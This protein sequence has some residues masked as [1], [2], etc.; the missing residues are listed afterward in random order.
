M[1]NLYIFNYTIVKRL[2]K[3]LIEREMKMKR[4]FILLNIFVFVCLTVALGVRQAAAVPITTLFNTGVNNDGT[5]R[6][7]GETELHYTI[8]S[9]PI[10]GNLL[11]RTSAGGFPISTGAWTDDNTISTWITP[12]F[13]ED[14][15][16]RLNHPPGEYNYQT[17]F[18]MTGY[19]T[20]SALITGNWIADDTGRLYFNGVDTG[21]TNSTS[22]L[23]NSGFLSGINTLEFRVTNSNLLSGNPT[24]LR[25][26]MS[27]TANPIPEPTTIALLGIGLAGLAGVEVRR[28][29][30]KESV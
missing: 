27:G 11:V 7:N 20:S 15:N 10:T 9:G 8:T 16:N 19:V 13:D 6:S 26:E 1:T 23:I 14:I 28:R 22:F 5:V 29:L 21:S 24:G 25:V 3:S 4:Y 30:K 17:T 2:Q 18:D 12:N